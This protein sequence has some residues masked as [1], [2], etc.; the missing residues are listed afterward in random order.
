MHLPLLEITMVSA[1]PTVE[2]ITGYLETANFSANYV[3]GDD[4]LCDMFVRRILPSNVFGQ[5]SLGE[6]MPRRAWW[7]EFN[8][9]ANKFILRCSYFDKDNTPITREQFV[10]LLQENG[11]AAE[12]VQNL[13]AVLYTPEAVIEWLP[14]TENEWTTSF[15]VSTPTSGCMVAGALSK[16]KRIV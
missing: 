7:I 11:W 10:T 3:C 16:I 15:N 12:K 14:T 4:T 13:P 6:N 2:E 1:T 5:T 9:D 8:E